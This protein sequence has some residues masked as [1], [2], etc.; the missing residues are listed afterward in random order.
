MELYILDD[1]YRR[2]EVVE[3][4]ESFI[5]TERWSDQGDFVLDIDPAFSDASLF[6]KGKMI[7]CDKSDRIMIVQTMNNSKS[8]EGTRLLKITGPS[9]ESVL[10]EKLNFYDTMTL[11]GSTSTENAPIAKT[12]GGAGQKPMDILRAIFNAAC[13]TNSIVA[14]DVIPRMQSGDYY[15]K[16]GMI[17]D[18]LVYPTIQSQIGVLWDTLKTICD[19]YRLGL[20]IVRIEN[21]DPTQPANL[22][23]EVYSGFDRTASQTVLPAIIFSEQLDNLTDTSELSSISGYKNIAYVTAPHGTRV[24]LSYDLLTAPTGTARKVLLVDASDIT[25]AAGSGLQNKLE[26]RGQQELAK[27][28]PITGF[29][30]KIPIKSG[31][32]YRTDYFLGDLVEQRSESGA[33]RIMRVTEQIFVSD[34]EGE[35]SYP[36]LTQDSLV[37]SGSWDAVLATKHW[38]DYTT[39]KWDSM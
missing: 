32:T 30:G 17:A 3:Q 19:T 26:Q 37:V 36:T 9:F 20:R 28:R 13:V 6:E 31:L 10:E 39:E 15:S 35:R 12:W 2:I 22:Y 33:R 25:D 5:W 7:A 27:T 21:A 34:K 1:S 29:D 16:T 8:E 24:V 14:A 11:A 23:F 4:F 18:M 38:D